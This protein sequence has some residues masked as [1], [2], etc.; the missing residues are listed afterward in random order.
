MSASVVQTLI[1][2]VITIN[3]HYI[4]CQDKIIPATLM[5]A[6]QN[7][8]VISAI[9]FRGS[10]LSLFDLNLNGNVSHVS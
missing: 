7:A 10:F 6:P 8:I 9:A 1:F 3:Q 5:N 4:N 2:I